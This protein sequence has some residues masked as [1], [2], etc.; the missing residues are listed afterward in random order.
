MS[1]ANQASQADQANQDRLTRTE[2]EEKVIQG[3]EQYTINSIGQIKNIRTN[4]IL[5]QYYQYD[6]Y[7]MVCLMKNNKKYCRHVI[8]LHKQYF[9]DIYMLD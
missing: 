5:K 9:P 1:Q 3:F 6:I 2:I 8:P 7:P 4:K